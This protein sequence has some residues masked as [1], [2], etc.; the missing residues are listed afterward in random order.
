MAADARIKADAIDNGFGVEAFNL[1]R[2][3]RAR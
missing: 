3:Y 1:E 2:K